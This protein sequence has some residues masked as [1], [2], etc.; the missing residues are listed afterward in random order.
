MADEQGDGF[1]LSFRGMI[2]KWIPPEI[3]A[4]RHAH[5]FDDAA[6]FSTTGLVSCCFC[7]T[8]AVFLDAKRYRTQSGV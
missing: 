8:F 6:L 4:T 1:S 7:R 3:G 5:N 2:G